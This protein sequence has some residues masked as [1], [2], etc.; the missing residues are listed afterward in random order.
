M[1][2]RYDRVTFEL[3]MDIF[4]G[5]PIVISEGRGLLHAQ[6]DPTSS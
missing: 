6:D 1:T 5:C 4:L 3:V 2:I